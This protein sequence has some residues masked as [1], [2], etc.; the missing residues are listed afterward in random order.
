MRIRFTLVEIHLSTPLVFW[1]DFSIAA[2][3]SFCEIPNQ[4]PKSKSSHKQTHSHASKMST[5]SSTQDKPD[6]ENEELATFFNLPN[7]LPNIDDHIS[8]FDDIDKLVNEAANEHLLRE[9]NK[10]L[11]EENSELKLKAEHLKT[12]ASYA[13]AIATDTAN[14][15]KAAGHNHALL[16]DRYRS[17]AAEVEELRKENEESQEKL[18]KAPEVEELR[19]ENEALKKKN[20]SMGSEALAILESKVAEWKEKYNGAQQRSKTL[21]GSLARLA[22]TSEELEKKLSK[23]SEIEAGLRRQNEQLHKMASVES[24]AIED[25]ESQVAELKEKCGK[26]EKRFITQRRHFVAKGEEINTFKAEYKKMVAELKTRN[27]GQQEH[28]ASLESQIETLKKKPEPKPEPKSEPLSRE[29]EK[30]YQQALKHKSELVEDLYKKNR[31]ALEWVEK[32]TKLLHTLSEKNNKLDKKNKRL[33]EQNKGLDKVL[34]STKKE[35]ASLRTSLAVAQC[36]IDEKEAH[37]ALS[38]RSA[39][40]SK[41]K[42]KHTTEHAHTQA[43]LEQPKKPRTQS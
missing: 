40:R 24:A 20:T 26:A 21:K 9:E 32:K 19:K 31:E 2:T 1:R 12:Q 18:S 34:V 28:I 42:R 41:R 37:L 17:V 14:R 43:E 35:V 11:K 36:V 39:E 33:D 30:A 38:K 22:A 8:S 3:I 27:K 13:Y 16:Q 25:L 15:L 10:A 5:D 6:N 23:A 29:H 7:S 4:T